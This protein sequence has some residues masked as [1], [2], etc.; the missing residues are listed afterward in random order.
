MCVALG[1]SCSTGRNTSSSRA[2]HELKSRYNI[3]HNAQKLYDNLIEVQLTSFPENRFELLPFYNSYDVKDKILTGGPFDAVIDKAEKAI[4]KHSISAKPKRDPSKAYSE[5]YRKWLKKEEFNPFM[6]QVWLLLGKAHL[7]NGDYELALSVFSEILKLFSDDIDLT[8]EAQLYMVRTYTEMNRFFDAQNLIFILQSRNLNGDLKKL[9]SETYANYLLENKQFEESVPFIKSVIEGEKNIVRKKRFQ[10]LLGQVYL[11]SADYYNAEKSFK[12]LKGL[13]TPK[14]LRLYADFYQNIFSTAEL[15]KDSITN[16]LMQNLLTDDINTLSYRVSSDS[17][18]IQT[19]NNIYVQANS[20]EPFALYWDAHLKRNTNTPVLTDH[21]KYEIE[22]EYLKNY[23]SPHFLILSLSDQSESINEL[24]FQTANLNFS[25]FRLRTFNI[26]QVRI[27]RRTAL[28][29]EP[30]NSLED[31]LNYYH[32]LQTDSIYLNNLPTIITPIIISKENFDILQNNSTL[33]EYN[34]FYEN[35]I[36][37]KPE[38]IIPKDFLQFENNISSMN[39][40]ESLS[41]KTDSI[42][43]SN[44]TRLSPTV[45]KTSER[46]KPSE[47]K[48]SLEQKASEMMRREDKPASTI[49]RTKLI[50]ERERLR[51][52]RI[53][54]REKELKERQRQREKEI[55]LREKERDSRVRNNK[56]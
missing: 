44:Y 29:L 26:T 30:F 7:Q 5:E 31:V 3:Y 4:S 40:E 15:K 50:K 14:E 38:I 36:G 13:K 42:D 10:Y 56:Q 39:I 28:R 45:I 49:D 35:E 2:Y 41:L 17:S 20:S 18:N 52:E 21:T 51:R 23:S 48:L 25:N 24:L 55:K 43:E 11:I 34:L 46:L 32:I 47:I 19:D 53:K 27:N 12:E 33:N 1:L 6:S 9:F 8:S 54:Q 22:R 37:I 16:L